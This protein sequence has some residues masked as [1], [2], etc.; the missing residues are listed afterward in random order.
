MKECP[1]CGRENLNVYIYCLGCG[2]GFD[3][4]DE[5]EGKGGGMMR[6]LGVPG[7]AAWLRGGRVTK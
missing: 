6:K 5:D 7:L 2:R 4:P 1:W 3:G